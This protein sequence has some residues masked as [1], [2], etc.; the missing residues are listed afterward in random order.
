VAERINIDEYGRR[1]EDV[2]GAFPAPAASIGTEQPSPAR[3][4]GDV[5]DGG[6]SPVAVDAPEVAEPAAPESEQMA[7]DGGAPSDQT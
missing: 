1:V 6:P 2:Y 3:L 4:S 7:F 5:H